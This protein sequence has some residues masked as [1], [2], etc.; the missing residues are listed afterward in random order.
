MVDLPTPE[1]PLMTT[2]SRVG[3]TM[4]C[5]S[6]WV[7][8]T[9]W[10]LFFEPID[11]ALD[12]T[13]CLAISPSL[14]LEPTVLASR[15]QFL[16]QKVKLAAGVFVARA[17]LVELIQV[18]AGREISSLMSQ[19]S[20]KMATSLRSDSSSSL[21]LAFWM[22]ASTRWRSRS[23][24]SSTTY[25]ARTSTLSKHSRMRAEC[26][27]QILVQRLPL[28]GACRAVCRWLDG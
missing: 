20:A 21:S 25:G 12:V 26:L 28:D 14:A 18:G 23:L 24:Y 8:S 3:S 9:F 27:S 19:R 22:R 6:R 2:A 4:E 15:E 1:G 17:Q 13:V 5:T 11:V 10:D 7:H 16:G